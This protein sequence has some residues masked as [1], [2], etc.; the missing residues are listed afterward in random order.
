MKIKDLIATSPKWEHPD[1]S[2]RLEAVTQLQIDD[3]IL[4]QLIA[5]DEDLQVRCAA[6]GNLTSTDALLELM[7]GDVAVLNS[8]AKERYKEILKSASDIDPYLKDIATLNDDEMLGQI[9]KSADSLELKL[10][11]LQRITAEEAL[12]EIA[13]DANQSAV[14]QAAIQKI[15]GQKALLA[16]LRDS[17]GKDK[18]V[19]KIAKEK[20]SEIHSVEESKQWLLQEC[21]LIVE[22]ITQH[23]KSVFNP[24]FERTWRNLDS[25]WQHLQESFESIEQEA[26]RE[27]LA[28][29]KSTFTS[30]MRQCEE[31]VEQLTTPEV[32]SEQE[33]LAALSLCDRLDQKLLELAGDGTVLTTLDQFRVVV[34]EEWRNL[35]I[36]A[37]TPT[38]KER[39]F[40]T[41][42]KLDAIA[43]ANSKWLTCK[44]ELERLL[45]PV[46]EQFESTSRQ[47]LRRVLNK[48]AWPDIIQPPLQIQTARQE[49]ERLD[50]LHNDNIERENQSKAALT[51]KLDQLDQAIESGSLKK[52]DKLFKEAQQSITNSSASNSQQDRISKLTVKIRELRDWQGYAT[53]PKREELCSK[54]EALLTSELHPRDKADRIKTL[55]EEWKGLG[56]SHSYRSQK[57]WHRFRQA[58]DSAYQPCQEYFKEQ[59]KLRQQNLKERKIICTHL[60]SFLDQSDWEN[61]NWKGVADIIQAAKKEW[62]R[63]ENINRA[64]RKGIQNRFYKVLDQLQA[65]LLVEQN[66]NRDKKKALI[67]ELK[68]LV[69]ESVE[70]STA[71]NRAKQLQ[72]EWKKIG[73]TPLRADQ[74]LWKEFRSYCDQVFE[75]RSKQIQAGKEQEQATR[76]EA[77]L[78]CRELETAVSNSEQST[79]SISNAKLNQAGRSFDRLNLPQQARTLL[80]ERFDRARKAYE[81]ALKI[82]KINERL[83]VTVELKRKAELCCVLE[84]SPSDSD[85][86]SAKQAWQG[87]SKQQLPP[88]LEERITQRWNFAQTITTLPPTELGEIQQTNLKEAQLLCIRI[89]LLAGIESPADAQP[90]KMEYQVSRLNKELSRGEKETRTSD[91]QKRHCSWT[92]IASVRYP[93]KTLQPLPKDLNSLFPNWK[94]Q[95]K[96]N[97]GIFIS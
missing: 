63:F 64:K 1:P 50:Q 56:A 15:S 45:S 62:R 4:L 18:N 14:R 91:E 48:L 44:E 29:L 77:E 35:Q 41:L 7:Q 31:V 57:L 25:R 92:G 39:Y 97:S 47:D 60:E 65:K 2:V 33:E 27:R 34:D 52:A 26:D 82:Q 76:D 61:V 59:E 23:A 58:A 19:H 36:S 96:Q 51:E 21:E 17:L 83:A 24:S 11:S 95:A 70:L 86:D 85:L 74:S 9:A 37:I 54:M 81:G 69:D 88:E 46:E 66:K 75:R 71:I 94:E 20:L 68:P 87:E 80:R 40:N 10:A 79:D 6:V 12:A 43:V 72:Q 84:S 53:N 3:S 13:L 49:L 55:Q 78:L 32:D 67:E 28:S 30:A 90:L 5:D 16:V 42:G 22:A 38:A 93:L 89:E 73:V 8:A